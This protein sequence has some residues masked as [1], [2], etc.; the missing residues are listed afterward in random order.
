VLKTANDLFRKGCEPRLAEFDLLWRPPSGRPHKLLGLDAYR[1]CRSRYRALYSTAKRGHLEGNPELRLGK[2]F[3]EFCE[4]RRPQDLGG[5]L[6]AIGVRPSQSNVITGYGRDLDGTPVLGR[7]SFHSPRAISSGAPPSFYVRRGIERKRAVEIDQRRRL[8]R[9]RQ[10]R[11]NTPCCNL[12]GIA[13]CH[14]AGCLV[15]RAAVERASHR[16]RQ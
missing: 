10:T 5:L 3:W 9:S 8:G 15:G 16:T 13:D 11:V 7:E 1:K 12:A 6:G 4:K 14:N 2:N